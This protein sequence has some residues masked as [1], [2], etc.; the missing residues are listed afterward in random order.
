L[1]IEPSR[2][3]RAT[4][5]LSM[6]SSAGEATTGDMQFEKSDGILWFLDFSP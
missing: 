3:R 1:A 4:M 6:A 2:W 5:R